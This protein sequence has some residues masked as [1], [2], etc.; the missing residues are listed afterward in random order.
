MIRLKGIRHTAIAFE[1]KKNG[2]PSG[3]ASR[4]LISTNPRRS[5]NLLERQEACARGGISCRYHS[6][7][8]L[9]LDSCLAVAPCCAMPRTTDLA[10]RFVQQT[11][12]IKTEDPSRDFQTRSPRDQASQF[13]FVARLGI[14]L[15]VQTRSFTLFDSSY[16]EICRPCPSR[17]PGQR[18]A[19]FLVS[20]PFAFRRK[21]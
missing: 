14:M 8:L 11:G 12:K 13:A 15:S 5:L 19:E 7:A 3:L 9:R 1:L 21:S 4:D 6:S 10:T 17:K 16:A 20:D 2:R 18:W